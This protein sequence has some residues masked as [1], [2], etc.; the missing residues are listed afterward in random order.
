[1]RRERG[2]RIEHTGEE[3]RET[4]VG[5]GFTCP[6]SGSDA[7]DE[8]QHQQHNKEKNDLK[9]ERR[10]GGKVATTTERKKGSNNNRKRKWSHN[11]TMPKRVGGGPTCLFVTRSM[12]DRFRGAAVLFCSSL[13]SW[14][15]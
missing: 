11:E 6:Y 2:R 4:E 15:V 10:K 12:L 8:R 1:M 9:T 5:R 7:T 13:V 3:R 14:P